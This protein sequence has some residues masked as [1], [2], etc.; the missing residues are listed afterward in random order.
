LTDRRR[1]VPSSARPV[2]CCAPGLNR[3]RLTK[4]LV[5]WPPPG[6]P[7]PAK[8]AL[9]W[10]ADQPSQRFHQAQYLE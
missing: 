2:S 3:F 5:I 4:Y 1:T 6:E 10:L 7:H 9:I 8:A